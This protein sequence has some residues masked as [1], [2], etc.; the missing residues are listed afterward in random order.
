M[1]E[2]AERGSNLLQS[3]ENSYLQKVCLW[4]AVEKKKRKLKKRV[5]WAPV[6]ESL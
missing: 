5:D 2:H 3:H 4:L 6:G 1:K